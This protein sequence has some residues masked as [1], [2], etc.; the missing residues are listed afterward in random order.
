M[1]SSLEGVCSPRSSDSYFCSLV[2]VVLCGRVEGTPAREV[3][4]LGSSSEWNLLYRVTLSQSLD[5]YSLK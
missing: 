5:V 4:D 1:F 3:R 2:L